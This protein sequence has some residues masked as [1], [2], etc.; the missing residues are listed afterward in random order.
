ML[1]R[2]VRV[3]AFHASC[4]ACA[5]R[6]EAALG[7]VACGASAR[8]F[9]RQQERIRLLHEH[10]VHTAVLT[11][12]AEATATSSTIEVPVAMGASPSPCCTSI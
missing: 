12:T 7:G 6:E 2:I 11:T 4:V 10:Q 8:P 9:R 5:T 1:S 3:Y